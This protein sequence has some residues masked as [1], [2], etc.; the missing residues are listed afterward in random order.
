MPAHTHK[1]THI[2]T[3]KIKG[4]VQSSTVLDDLDLSQ[5]ITGHLADTDLMQNGSLVRDDLNQINSLHL[6]TS[7]SLNIMEINRFYYLFM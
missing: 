2:C 1:H 3:H 4:I 6:A 5:V 7:M